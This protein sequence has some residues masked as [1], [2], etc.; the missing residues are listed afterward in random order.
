MMRT[1]RKDAGIAVVFLCSLFFSLAGAALSAG[2]AAVVVV[3]PMEG[4]VGVSLENYLDE[5]FAFAAKE[6]AT[7]LVISIDTPGGLVTSMRGMSQKNPCRTPSRSGLGGTARSPGRFCRSFPGPGCPR[8]G[9]GPGD[10]HRG[11]APR[12]RFGAGRAR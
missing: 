12:Y 7:L 1:K 9:H 5:A 3:A 4:V 6:K 10:E 8:C 2:E 11:C